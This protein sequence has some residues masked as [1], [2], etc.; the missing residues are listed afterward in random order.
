[1]QLSIVLR[2]IAVVII[3]IESGPGHLIMPQ[4][5]ILKL[6]I[7]NIQIIAK[8]EMKQQGTRIK[9]SYHCLC[10]CSKHLEWPPLHSASEIYMPLW[11]KSCLA[12]WRVCLL[13]NTMGIFPVMVSNNF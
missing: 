7:L 6:R 9:G 5:L 4:R 13:R 8:R 2:Y 3:S 10:I 11:Q 12:S 1:M